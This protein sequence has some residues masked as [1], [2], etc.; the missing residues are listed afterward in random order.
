MELPIARLGDKC[1]SPAGIS[2]T[3][4]TASTDFFV[5]GRGA[6]RVG[7][8]VTYSDGTTTTCAQGD[9][10]VFDG[11]KPIVRQTFVLADG[12]KV[13]QGSPRATS[14]S[15][16]PG[17]GSVTEA[18]MVAARRSAAA[19]VPLQCESAAASG[20]DAAEQ[21]DDAD[22]TGTPVP[23]TRDLARGGSQAFHGL[24]RTPAPAEQTSSGPDEWADADFGRAAT[25]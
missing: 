7:D 10:F 18:T 12:G 21:S 25:A 4:T 22:A 2:G 5:D 15:P 17:A 3:I 9:P 13:V 20:T 19:F 14:G 11:P 24:G 1:V 23:L 6:A 8:T 16:R